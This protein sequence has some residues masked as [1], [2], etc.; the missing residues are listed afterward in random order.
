MSQAEESG[1]SILALN[2]KVLQAAQAAL[3]IANSSEQQV[4]GVSQVAT[5]ME[6]IKQASSQNVAGTKQGEI[7]A[8][9]LNKVGQ[10]LKNL[11]EQFSV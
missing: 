7:A 9:N 1:K 2:E 8:Q 11:A 3:Q 6:N 5:A 10:N 4:S